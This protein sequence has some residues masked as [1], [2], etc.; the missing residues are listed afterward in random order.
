MKL[1]FRPYTLELKNP[2]G[3]AHGTRNTTAIVL[4]QLEHKGIIG[5]GEASLPPYHG[6][7][8]ESVKAFLSKLELEQFE[9]PEET[10]KILSYVD[11][12]EKGNNAA[13]ASID[14]ALHDLVGKILRKPCY[15]LFGIKTAEKKLSS[16]T[17]AID[18]LKNLPRKIKEAKDDRTHWQ[19]SH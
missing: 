19:I 2:F 15:E 4:T 10:E 12:I 7:T 14:I 6:E 9:N 1:S 18:E 5:Y 17:I 3:L 13:K 8:Q 11:K 16:Y